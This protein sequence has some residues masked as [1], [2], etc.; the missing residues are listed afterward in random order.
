MALTEAGRA[1]AR[2]PEQALSPDQLH[3]R[4]LRQLP[5]PEGKLLTALIEAYPE[6]LTNEELAE[7]AGYA[8]TGGAF[9]NPRGRLRSLGLIDYRGGRVHALPVLFLE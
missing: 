1:L 6:G 3:A 5:G 9:A 4:V 7:R 2:A 8:P